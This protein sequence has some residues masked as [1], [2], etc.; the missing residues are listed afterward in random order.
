M[1]SSFCHS[2]FNTQALLF[3]QQS[4]IFPVLV[5]TW[6]VPSEGLPPAYVYCSLIVWMLPPNPSW[7]VRVRLYRRMRPGRCRRDWKL[8]FHPLSTLFI[9][10]VLGGLMISPQNHNTSGSLTPSQNDADSQ[11][12]GWEA[13]CPI[14][15]SESQIAQNKGWLKTEALTR[16]SYGWASIWSK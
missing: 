11:M 5:Q 4:P 8:P 16:A 3:D 15:K 12:Q 14:P 7:P 2:V 13:A 6:S 1:I 10:A 9:T